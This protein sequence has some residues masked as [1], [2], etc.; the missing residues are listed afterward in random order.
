M[1]R[2]K[3]TCRYLSKSN[4]NMLL[5]FHS[6]ILHNPNPI[7][8]SRRFG[9]QVDHQFNRDFFLKL[10]VSDAKLQNPRGSK[11]S[12][13]CRGAD[14]VPRCFSA[15]SVD[16]VTSKPKRS[17]KQPPI[18][19]SVS[20]F[21]KSESPEEVKLLSLIIILFFLAFTIISLMII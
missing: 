11:K 18:S 10:W 14:L 8:L 6:N 21:S 12:I 9:T 13:K 5:H 1:N 2:L 3:D 16:S 19:Q 17:I 7:L 4:I 15:A 20:E